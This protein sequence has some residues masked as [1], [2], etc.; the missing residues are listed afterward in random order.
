MLSGPP[1]PYRAAMPTETN[2]GVVH[3]HPHPLGRWLVRVEDDPSTTTEHPTVNIA[4]RQARRRASALGIGVVLV[5]DRYQRV[6]ESTV[7]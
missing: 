2:T 3:V 4:E 6:H 5:H 7:R 1:A